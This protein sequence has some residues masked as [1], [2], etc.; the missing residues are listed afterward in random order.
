MLDSKQKDYIKDY[1]SQMTTSIDEKSSI[2]ISGTITRMTGMKIEVTG[3]S[4]PLGS[5]CQILISETHSIKAEVIGFNENITYL[6]AIDGIEGIKPGARVIA[7]SQNNRA[8]VGMGLLGR[9]IDAEGNPIDG[10]GPVKTEESYLL[11]PQPINPLTRK[12]I[13]VPLDVGIRAINSLLTVGKGQRLGIFAGSGVGKSVLLGM[14]TKFTQAHVV[15]VGLVGERGREVKEFIEK[16]LGEEGLKKSVVVAAPADTSPLMRVNAAVLATT[17]AEY[18]RDKGLDVL[19]IIDSLT[20]Y[21]QS[22]REISLSVGEL[23]ATKGFTPSVFAKVASLLE[24]TGNG[25]SSQ[26]SITAFYTVLVEGDDSADPVA[27]HARSVLDG[28]IVLSRQLA[29]SGHYPAIDIEKSISRVMNSVVNNE[30]MMLS[31]LFKQLYSAYMQNKE[32]INVG[33]YQFGSDK[34]IDLGI[35]YRDKM[36]NFLRQ[37]IDESSLFQESINQLQQLF[38]GE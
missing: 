5:I 3:L 36:L 6:M 21:A 4:V 20:R 32:L 8:K 31:N 23:P 33:M 19:L 10:R 18:Y 37:G 14:M 12:N 24:R 7:V 13:D 26:G 28:H 9:V 15:V 34:T 35:K 11:A 22:Q 27:D 1:L 17:I 16:N 25:T 29:D 2:M 30:I 38:T